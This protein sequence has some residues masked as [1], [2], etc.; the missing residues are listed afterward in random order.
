MGKSGFDPNRPNHFMH[1]SLG[2][3][4]TCTGNHNHP[5]PAGEETIQSFTL[6]GLAALHT[7]MKEAPENPTLPHRFVSTAYMAL[8]GGATVDQMLS[9]M[10]VP[11]DPDNEKKVQDML[12]DMRGE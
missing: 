9:A 1:D 3:P 6:A 10:G 2:D 7:E 12:N 5:D 11:K 8:L 4:S